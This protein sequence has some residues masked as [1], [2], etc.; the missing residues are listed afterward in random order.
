MVL[1]WG[2]KA[3]NKLRSTEREVESNLDAENRKLATLV[4]NK[5]KV[6]RDISAITIKIEH[7]KQNEQKMQV[8]KLNVHQPV[9]YYLRLHR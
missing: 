4:K 6:E 7:G 3:L 2:E 5:R 9:S 1:R 8:D